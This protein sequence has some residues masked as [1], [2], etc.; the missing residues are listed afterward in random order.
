M[1]ADVV[2]VYLHAL[3]GGSLHGSEAAKGL[4]PVT[5][6]SVESF[7][8]VVGWVEVGTGASVGACSFAFDTGVCLVVSLVAE[9]LAGRLLV[10]VQLVGDED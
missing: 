4:L 1:L 3:E 8:L 10:G 5:D 6:R 2:V 7:H 9:H